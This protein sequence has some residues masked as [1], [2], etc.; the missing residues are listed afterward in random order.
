MQRF[1]AETGNNWVVVGTEVMST[2][3]STAGTAGFVLMAL[4]YVG[5][6]TMLPLLVPA[7]LISS[8]LVAAA[9]FAHAGALH[10]QFHAQTLVESTDQQREPEYKPSL[11]NK[12]LATGGILAATTAGASV[13]A[14]NPAAS[15]AVMALGVAHPVLAMATLGLA[16]N[17]LN[18]FCVNYGLLQ[19]AKKI[20]VQKP[21]TGLEH[22]GGFAQNQD[23]GANINKKAVAEARSLMWSSLVKAIGYSSMF[24]GSMTLAAS[25]APLLVA[26]GLVG[27]A[28]SHL[29]NNRAHIAAGLFGAKNVA[30]SID[31]GYNNDQSF[32]ERVVATTKMLPV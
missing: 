4:G 13:L 3:V 7:L 28:G 11:R 19:D 6:S 5:A 15:A 30:R 8:G 16:I 24:M 21:Q 2:A 26:A 22:D 25:F 14:F 18:D 32:G 20:P 29:Y 31:A 10:L 23:D 27:V 17:A 1:F 12:E 9:K